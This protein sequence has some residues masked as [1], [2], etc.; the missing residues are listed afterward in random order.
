MRTAIVHD[1]LTQK[2]GAERVVL[3]MHRAFLDAP[4]YTSVFHPN[5]TFPDFSS[6]DI[7]T[8]YL[9]RF[10]FIRNRH[11]L[12]FPFLAQAFSRLHVDAAVTLCSS[13][14]WAHG[15]RTTG[16]KI[17]YC[18][19]PAR[20]IYQP[21]RYLSARQ[22]GRR[23]ALWA[24]RPYLEAWD[25]R[26]AGTADRYLTHS[27]VVRDRIK[28]EYDIDAELLRAPH[29]MDPSAPQQPVR[30]LEEGFLLTVARLLPYKNVG[31]VV[32]AF[33]RL[34]ERRLVVVGKGPQEQWLRSRAPDN[35]R[36]CGS[37][38]DA[39]LRWLYANSGGLVAASYEDYGLTPL[40]AAAFGKPTAA[41][42]WG[43]YL[44]TVVEGRTGVFFPAPEPAAI[45]RAVRE[46]TGH[47][48]SQEPI[49]DHSEDFSEERF[50]QRLRAIVEQELAGH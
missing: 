32:E 49:R 22:L 19:T 48:W 18:H 1:Y 15:V 28:R 30:G 13:S 40:E 17:V 5:R 27:R 21:D 25:R 31:S 14:G 38:S 35:V 10:P 4:I 44:D 50:T 26:M 24:L 43:G 23:A 11:R 6:A 37:V 7:R 45:E 20:W 41:L 42:R 34:P 9:Q 12:A 46:M 47:P 33:T 2:G 39:E 8:L 16:R 36:F 3:A 29:S